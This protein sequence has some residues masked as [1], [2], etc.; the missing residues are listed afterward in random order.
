LLL[1]LV[2]CRRARL[3]FRQWRYP[4]F[5]ASDQESVLFHC[6][7]ALIPSTASDILDSVDGFRNVGPMANVREMQKASQKMLLFSTKI[8]G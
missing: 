6:F 2:P 7:L 3:T 1:H 5:V 4:I 8:I